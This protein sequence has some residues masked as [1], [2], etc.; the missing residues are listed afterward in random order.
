MNPAGSMAPC[1]FLGHVA[2]RSSADLGIR[3]NGKAME[4]GKVEEN[5]GLFL[6]FLLF[7][8]CWFCF[9]FGFFVAISKMEVRNG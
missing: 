8:Q 9:L 5:C 1:G 4:D 6:L 7:L 3:E 2:P